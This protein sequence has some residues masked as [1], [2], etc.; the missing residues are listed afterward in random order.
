MRKVHVLLCAAERMMNT[1]FKVVVYIPTD[2]NN[3]FHNRERD[4]SH[5][6][7]F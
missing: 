3:Q 7:I 5:I 1:Q 2:T 6:Y 4:E